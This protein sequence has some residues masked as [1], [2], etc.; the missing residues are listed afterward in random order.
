MQWRRVLSSSSGTILNPYPSYV[1][2][3]VELRI[4][5]STGDE[6]VQINRDTAVEMAKPLSYMKMNVNYV[7]TNPVGEKRQ[8]I[9][10][11]VHGYPGTHQS[12]MNLIEEFQR[13]NF[14][15]I[16]PDM[17]CKTIESMNFVISFFSMKIA[18]RAR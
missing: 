11:L 18:A 3:Q 7:D 8:A 4:Q 16:A 13:R 15:C 2:R 9:V 17:P 14:R 6:T 12:T 5:T 10:L 1:E